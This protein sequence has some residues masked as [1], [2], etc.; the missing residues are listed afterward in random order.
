VQDPAVTRIEC[1][2]VDRTPPVIMGKEAQITWLRGFLFNGD[3]LINLI[4]SIPR[5][6]NANTA[7]QTVHEA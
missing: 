5:Q 7:M 3:A 4:L 2:V 1:D 6:L